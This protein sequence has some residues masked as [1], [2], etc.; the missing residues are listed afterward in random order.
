MEDII[1]KKLCNFCKN[2]SENCNKQKSHEKVNN[3]II[4]K[5]FN[6]QKDEDKVEGYNEKWID[7]AL[8][9]IREKNKRKGKLI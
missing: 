7:N 6:Y 9:D 4:Y 3:V 8:I 1:D 2:K 5:C